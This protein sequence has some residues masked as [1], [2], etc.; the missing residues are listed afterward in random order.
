MSHYL[1]KRLIESFYV[2]FAITLIGFLVFYFDPADPVDMLTRDI[3]SPE[4]A[5]ALRA[6]LGLDQPAYMQYLLYVQRLLQ[7]DL[8]VSY[9]SGQPVA[10]HL[11]PALMATA[12]FTL[13]ALF[14]TLLIGIPAGIFSAT[15]PY[16]AA[17]SAVM[18]IVLVGVSAPEFWI[19]ILLIW[20]FAYQLGWLPSGGSIGW[21]SVILP[22]FTLALH[23]GA[24]VARVTRT[25]ILEVLSQDYIRTARAKGLNNTV[26]F[27]KHA[28][29]NA[30]LPITTIVGLQIASM[31]G[32]TITLENVFAWPGIGRMLVV[33][34]LQRD[35]P[36]VQGC[37]LVIAIGVLI[38]NALTDLLYAQLDPTVKARR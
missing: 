34:I 30:S 22:A 18:S 3:A 13:V 27:Y 17:D 9:R 19:G 7:G 11:L 29:R 26:I 37:I 38:L 4:Y 21:A 36:I 20:L 14:I 28:L 31:L 6:R 10:A 1:L 12:W 24:I 16:T 2:V 35:A 33:A 32:G 25:G 8:G 5:E 15:R 23:Y